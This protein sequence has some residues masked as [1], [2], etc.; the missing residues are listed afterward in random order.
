MCPNKSTVETHATL[1]KKQLQQG[2]A[3]MIELDALRQH[4]DSPLLPHSTEHVLKLVLIEVGERLQRKGL[5]EAT[6][7]SDNTPAP[8]YLIANRQLIR[9]IA[10]GQTICYGDVSI[11]THSEL[12]KLRR[13]QDAAFLG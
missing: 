1:N 9:D 4:I 12:L 7:A 10:P 6:P 5:V 3:P 13:Q 11:E 8:F 2:N